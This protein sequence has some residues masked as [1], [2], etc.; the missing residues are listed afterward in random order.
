M[1]NPNLPLFEAAVRLL[2]P[3]LD[4]LAFVGGCATGLLVTDPAAASIRPTVD[5]DAITEVS[6]YAQYA[7]L[8]ERLR[9]VGLR[10]DHRDGAPTC[11]WRCADL[12]IDVMPTDERILGFSNPWYSPALATAQRVD[13]AGLRV[14]LVTAVYFLATKLVAF[15]A[16]GNDDY[17]GSHDLEDVITVIDGRLEI[18]A[19]SQNAA[20]DVQSYIGSEVSRLLGTRAF[21]DALPG[22]LLPDAASQARLSLVRDRLVALTGGSR[23]IPAPPETA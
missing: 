17:R 12:T 20:S 15:R 5:V 7:V 8:S 1:N 4:D 3:L 13:V 10:E 22:F 23:S 16:R 2:H 18:V 11:R 14:R 6:T 19:E 9:A 21:V